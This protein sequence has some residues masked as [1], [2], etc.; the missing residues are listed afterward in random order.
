MSC[1]DN[2]TQNISIYV[3]DMLAPF[4]VSLPSYLRDTKDRVR[5]LQEITISP[6]TRLTSLDVELLYMNISHELGFKAVCPFLE[7][8]GVQYKTHNEFIL[9]LL[10]FLLS[11]NYFIFNG[12][13]YQQKCGTAM[14][15]ACALN[16]ANLFLRWWEDKIVFSE[17]Y[18]AYTSCIS[19]WGSFLI[20]TK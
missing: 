13:F 12:K 6:Q 7:S 8:K 17:E 1:N 2:L 5:R 11:Y 18:V 4:F 3:N 19:F 20:P 10:G 14:G 16:Y 15:T 9:Q